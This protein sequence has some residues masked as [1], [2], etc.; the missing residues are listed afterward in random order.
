MSCAG[1]INDF[2]YL[3]SVVFSRRPAEGV[4]QAEQCSK[5][6]PPERCP[7]DIDR[8]TFTGNLV[9]RRKLQHTEEDVA[10]IEAALDK[11]VK[12]SVAAFRSSKDTVPGFGFQEKIDDC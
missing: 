4:G 7:N 5:A 6:R 11:A 3:C 9:I 8:I 1:R 12:L 2:D 10:Q